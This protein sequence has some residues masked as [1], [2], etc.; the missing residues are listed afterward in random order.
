M[1]LI[2]LD[3]Q[4]LIVYNMILFS[5]VYTT[6][7]PEISIKGDREIEVLCGDTA[8]FEVELQQAD[9]THWTITWQKNI[10]TRIEQIN[11]STSRYIDSTDRK[12]VIHSV[13]KEDKGNYQAVL[14]EKVS[15]GKSVLQVV[16]N[17]IF[18]H[19][20]GGNILFIN[21]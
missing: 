21:K 1:N 17:V 7:Q 12:L 5:I 16:S 9:L 2:K 18:L 20:P 19:T 6:D 14:S 15:N 3:F 4:I 10:A 13:C 8:C 11:T